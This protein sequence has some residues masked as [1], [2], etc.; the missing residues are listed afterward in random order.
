MER[1]SQDHKF[2]K[3]VSECFAAI[4]EHMFVNPISSQPWGGRN[5]VIARM[6]VFE[7]YLRPEDITHAHWLQKQALQKASGD[8]RSR[9]VGIEYLNKVMGERS[10]GTFWDEIASLQASGPTLFEY[11]EAEFGPHPSTTPAGRRAAMHVVP[12]PVPESKQP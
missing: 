6:K 3:A 10:N 4:G 2:S 9:E 5:R 8:W 1:Y 12:S 7:K 11:V